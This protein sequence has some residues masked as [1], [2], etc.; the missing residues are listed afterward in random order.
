MT[1]DQL[2]EHLVECLTTPIKGDPI[3]EPGDAEIQ[4]LQ[5]C[6]DPEALAS[7]VQ[8]LIGTEGS[9]PM[10]WLIEALCDDID[11]CFRAEMLNR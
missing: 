11:W 10:S 9:D 6:P 4:S 8:H 1:F 5:D 3:F 2:K 7:H